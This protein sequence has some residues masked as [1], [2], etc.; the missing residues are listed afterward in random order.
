MGGVMANML[1]YDIVVSEFK[2]Q[3]RYCVHFWTNT[4]EKGVNPLI[5]VPS[6]VFNSTTSVILQE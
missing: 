2:L 1:H 6:Y 4:L 5:P 3:S